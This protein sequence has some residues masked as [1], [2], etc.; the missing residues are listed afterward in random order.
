MKIL[1]PLDS[2]EEVDGLAK[3]GAGEF[4]CGVLEDSWYEKY[5]VISINRRPAG[6]GHFRRFEDLKEAVAKA[7]GLGIPVYF[8]V[9]EHYYTQ[10]QYDLIRRYLDG[11]TGAGVD[12]FIITDFGLLQFIQEQ[13]Y[14]AALHISTGGTVFNWRSAAFFKQLGASNI[15]F[16]RHL[17]IAEI[18]TIT[19]KM[20]PMDT[21]VFVLNSRCINIDGFCTFQHGLARKEVPPMFKNACMLPFEVQVCS[22]DQS[23]P[24]MRQA[25]MIERQRIWERVHVDDHPCGACALYEFKKLGIGSLK[26]VGRGNPIERKLRDVEF[27][28]TLLDRLDA[29]PGQAD[30]RSAARMLY[31]ATYKRPCRATMC[32]YPEVMAAQQE[33]P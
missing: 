23:V 30:F 4:F 2:I 29:C 6:K 26:V 22:S 24:F 27:L 18:E 8:T 1:S 3:A 5:P 20:P 28:K 13:G 11:A 33:G 7:H 9:N 21:T 17:S 12:A 16:P 15:T 32:Y 25:C 14:P 19:A 10:A 31:T